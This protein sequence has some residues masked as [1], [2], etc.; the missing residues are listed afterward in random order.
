ML[1]ITFGFFLCC[2]IILARNARKY[3]WGKGSLL[4]TAQ[5][6]LN[7]DLTHLKGYGQQQQCDLILWMML[8]LAESCTAM[9]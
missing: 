2:N 7:E 3:F 5:I 6:G 9:L 4:A 8:N 1:D